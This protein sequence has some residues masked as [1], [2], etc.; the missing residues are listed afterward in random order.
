MIIIQVLSNINFIIK[1]HPVQNIYFNFISKPFIL[2]KLPIDYWGLGNKKT[3][4][5]LLKK[6]D[7]FSISNSS[8]TPL[9]NLKFSKNSSLSYADVIKFNGTQEKYKINSDFIFTNYIFNDNPLNNKK[10]QIPKNYQSY[11]K[12]IIDGIIVNEIFIK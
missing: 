11:F 1:S 12:L 5:F 8:F 9:S 3:I 10:F 4:D 7:K 6:K 2:K